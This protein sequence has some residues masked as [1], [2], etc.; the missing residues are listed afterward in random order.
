[1]GGSDKLEPL[2]LDVTGEICP[3]PLLKLKL[4]LRNMSSH[5]EVVLLASDSTSL[6]DIPAF[7]RIAGH[8]L[9]E[10]ETVDDIYQFRIQ[11]QG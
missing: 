5:E 11:K 1:M 4:A 2:C 6:K 9:L 3:L 8:N 10:C 7:C